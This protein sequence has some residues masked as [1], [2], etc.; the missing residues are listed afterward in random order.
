MNEMKTIVKV[1]G[2]NAYGD[3]IETLGYFTDVRTA[4]R[5]IKAE[6]TKTYDWRIREID[7]LRFEKIKINKF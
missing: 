7:S 5:I 1:T 2:S 6:F 4:K 3:G